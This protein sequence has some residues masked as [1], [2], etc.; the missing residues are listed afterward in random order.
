MCILLLGKFP[1]DIDAD[2]E[3]ILKKIKRGK[4]LEEEDVD[5]KNISKEALNLMVKLLSPNPKDRPSAEVCLNMEWVQGKAEKVDLPSLD[6][7]KLIVA[8]VKPFKTSLLRVS[9]V[10]KIPDSLPL[11]NKLLKT[12]SLR[13]ATIAKIGQESE[14]KKKVLLMG[15]TN[16]GTNNFLVELHKQISTTTAQK[17]MESIGLVKDSLILR[18]T[19][20]NWTFYSYESSSATFSWCPIFRNVDLVIFMVSSKEFTKS[21]AVGHLNGLL[22]SLCAAVYFTDFNNNLFTVPLAVSVLYTDHRDEM[23]KEDIV[24]MLA[25]SSNNKDR[26]SKILHFNLNGNLHNT[27]FSLL[28]EMLPKSTEKN[29][30]LILP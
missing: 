4:R 27:W 28:T 22:G 6:T 30:R 19:A 18:V 12:A 5:D 15:T 29:Q 23:E 2:L 11:F 7:M 9:V 14:K 25:S 16:S 21:G 24:R 13:P 10:E 26:I 3:K 17:S 8:K 20:G 1:F